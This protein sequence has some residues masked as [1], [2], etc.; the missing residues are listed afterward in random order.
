MFVADW[1]GTDMG[2]EVRS[3]LEEVSDG[4]WAYVQDPGGWCVS[5]SGFIEAGGGGIVV[6]TL[7]TEKR[8]LAMKESYGKVGF[9]APEFIVNTHHHGD[10]HFGNSV[11]DDQVTIVGHV[12]TRS[13]ILVAG[14]GMCNLWPEVDWGNISIRPPEVTYSDSMRIDLADGGPEVQLLHFGPGHTSNDTL[15][16]LPKTRTLFCGDVAF[17]SAA[18][19][20][21]MGSAQGSISVLE[22]I[23]ALDPLVVVPGHG[24]VGG[25]QMVHDT[26]E[27]LEWIVETARIGY[28]SGY[29]ALDLATRVRDDK[30]FV[31]L[32]ESERL[33][34]NLEI[35]LAEIAGEQRSVEAMGESFKNMC[36]FH[37]GRPLSLA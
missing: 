8:T 26:L 12:Q 32:G 29:S 6:D 20:L 23:L 10:H 7:S 4:A 13:E 14:K 9:T 19:Y 17:P 24:R 18:P 36:L 3:F 25:I 11:F 35:A 15:V 2:A 21:L 31:H 30:R 37:G 34:T 1:D 16:W 33:L 27:Y 5:N 22:K 28:A